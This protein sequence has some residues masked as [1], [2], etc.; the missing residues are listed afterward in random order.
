[1][2]IVTSFALLLDFD[3]SCRHPSGRGICL[4]FTLQKIGMA[5][6]RFTI[7]PAKEF[8]SR[9]CAVVVLQ[10]CFVRFCTS[11]LVIVIQFRNKAQR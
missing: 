6:K 3:L 11:Q 5:F 7:S 10:K 8:L 1:M 2:I 9:H 4:T